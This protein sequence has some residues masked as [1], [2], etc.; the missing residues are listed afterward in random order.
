MK[1]NKSIVGRQ[2]E[3]DAIRNGLSSHGS[4]KGFLFIGEA[5]I[6]KSTMLEESWRTLSLTPNPIIWIAPNLSSAKDE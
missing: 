6:G 2:A 4:A 1:D 5:G 3:L